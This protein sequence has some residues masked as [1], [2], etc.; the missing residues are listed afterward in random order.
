MA[1]RKAKPPTI[2]GHGATKWNQDQSAAANKRG[3]ANNQGE[4]NKMLSMTWMIPVAGYV[5]K[6]KAHDTKKTTAELLRHFSEQQNPNI[7]K[8]KKDTDDGEHKAL[9]AAR[10]SSYMHLC[11]NIGAKNANGKDFKGDATMGAPFKHG[12]AKPGWLAGCGV[13]VDGVKRWIIV[14]D[15]TWGRAAAA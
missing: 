7:P 3:A 8:N 10:C 11:K 6:A 12:A 1:S 5:A 15:A 9:S 14:H 2:A 13:G 4:G